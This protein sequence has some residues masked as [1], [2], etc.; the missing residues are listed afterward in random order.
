MTN[1]ET[2]KLALEAL[3]NVEHV[4][5]STDWFDDCVAAALALKE[6]LTKQSTKFLEQ[7]VSV[8]EPVARCR[9]F[10]LRGDESIARHYIDW[11]NGP[12]AGDLYTTPQPKQELV[13]VCGTVWEGNEIVS[14]PQQRDS[15]A[16]PLKP[17]TD[18]QIDKAWRSVDYTVPWEQHRIDIAR[19]IEAAHGIIKE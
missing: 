5:G 13:C 10:P 14:S 1:K 3:E 19:A 16:T 8:G 6:A 2:L 12:V 7:S 4:S 9:V 15:S 18:E 11:V 17:L